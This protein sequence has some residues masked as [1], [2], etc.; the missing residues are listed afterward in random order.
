MAS[1]ELSAG[2]QEEAPSHDYRLTMF[3]WWH[4]RS[5]PVLQHVV[6][7]TAHIFSATG[8]DMEETIVCVC[9]YVCVCVC[10]RVYMYMC[11]CMFA[12]V[13]AHAYVFD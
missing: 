10:A 7:S 6:H 2:S 9:M 4:G 11:V 8:T 1:P 13:W 12:Y 5:L 3:H